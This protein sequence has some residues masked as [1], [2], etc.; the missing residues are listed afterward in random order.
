MRK[1]L[2]WTNNGSG[3]WILTTYDTFEEAIKHESYGSEKI[4]TTEV[5]YKITELK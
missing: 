1:Y 3:G 4:I 2:V 5:K